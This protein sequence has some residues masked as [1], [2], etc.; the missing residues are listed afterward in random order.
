MWFLFHH[1]LHLLLYSES[2]V[3]CFFMPLSPSAYLSW[4]LSS[5]VCRPFR[6]L[7]TWC[8]VSRFSDSEPFSDAS[9]LAF[10]SFLHFLFAALGGFLSFASFVCLSVS[11]MSLS[12]WASIFLLLCVSSL[13]F[14]LCW[15]LFQPLCLCLLLWLHVLFSLW[16]FLCLCAICVCHVTEGVPSPS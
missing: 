13:L 8:F 2:C 6:F 14:P 12:T 1:V 11:L 4:S 3:V 9:H 10:F 5:L 16:I 7:L 15:A